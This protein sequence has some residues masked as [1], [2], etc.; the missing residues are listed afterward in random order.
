MKTTTTQPVRIDTTG[1]TLIEMIGVIAIMGILAA[2]ITP[3][4]LRTLDRAAERAEADTLHNLGEQVKLSFKVNGWLPGLKPTPPFT[5]WDQ[6]LWTFADMNPADI[7]TNK[8]QM[9]RVFVLEPGAMPK[10][11]MLLSSM[12]SG[13]ALGPA[14]TAAAFTAVWNWNAAGDLTLFPPPAGWAAWNN[15]NIEYLVIERVNLQAVYMTINLSNN[16]AKSTNLVGYRI[17]PVGGPPGGL[18]T[19]TKGTSQTLTMRP[20][21]RLDLYNTNVGTGVPDYTYIVSSGF[22]VIDFDDTNFWTPQ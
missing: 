7:V 13:L 21:E 8:R 6:D 18:Q 20:N 4:A 15:T 10:R 19:L 3:N 22:K 2:V 12:R 17:Q 16:T 9:A 1:F 14:N 11:A 5:T